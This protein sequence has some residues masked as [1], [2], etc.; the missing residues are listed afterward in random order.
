MLNWFKKIKI[1]IFSITISF[2]LIVNAQILNTWYVDKNASGSN[3]GTTWSN[4]WTSFSNINWNSIKPGDILY[5]SG[6]SD[7]TI[8]NESLTIGSS[9]TLGSPIVI[10]K[11]TD[12]GHSGKVIIENISTSV[13]IIVGNKSNL[14]ISNLYLRPQSGNGVKFDGASNVVVEKLNIRNQAAGISLQN[15]NGITIRNCTIISVEYSTNQTDGIYSQRNRNIRIHDNYIEVRNTADNGHNDCIQSYQDGISSAHSNE[16]TLTVWNNTLYQNNTKTSNSSATMWTYGWGW[17]TAYNNLVV[18]PY[19]LVVG[20]GGQQNTTVG[21]SNMKFRIWNNTHIAGIHDKPIYFRRMASTDTIDV[22][23]NLVYNTYKYSKAKIDDSPNYKV[24]RWNNNSYYST[25]TSW[26]TIIM[27]NGSNLNMSAW[28]GLGFD[29]NSVIINPQM[30]NPI[31]GLNGLGD[32][33]LKENSPARDAGINLQAEVEALG[34]PWTDINGNPR[35][36]T[37][38]I[39]AYEFSNG[40]IDVT[41]PRVTSANLINA[42]TLI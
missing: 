27:L 41:P 23:N 21:A 29:K 7:S 31:I 22:A 16:N 42:N 33:S 14:T 34:M 11:S 36:N 13:S 1:L 24:K 38:N 17:F 37:P 10:T 5:I 35:D 40:G 9:G 39:G 19:S 25:N 3:I 6:G 30:V 26:S 28:Q 18:Q 8:Y 15:T 32:Y 20:L 4:A 12:Q 2:P